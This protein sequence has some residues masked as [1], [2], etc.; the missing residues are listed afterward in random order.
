MFQRQLTFGEAVTKCLQV[1]YCNFSGRASRSEFWW[2]EL[3]MLLV[4][5]L[6]SL[7]PMVLGDTVGGAITGVI[8]LLLILPTLGLMARRLHDIGRSAWWL[9]LILTGIGTI[10]LI[11]WWIMPSQEHP[12]EYGDEP[13]MVA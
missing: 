3:F 7:I 13:N 6:C 11:I 1:N 10:L 4:N 5:A 2:Y 9:L 12:N 8:S